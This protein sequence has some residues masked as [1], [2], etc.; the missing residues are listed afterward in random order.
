MAAA[1][2][3]STTKRD[4]TIAFQTRKYAARAVGLQCAES[5]NVFQRNSC[6]IGSCIAFAHASD[7]RSD[8]SSA[9]MQPSIFLLIRVLQN[10][11]RFQRVPRLNPELATTAVGFS[12]K[13]ISQRVAI[14]LRDFAFQETNH[15]CFVS[16]RPATST[17]GSRRNGLVL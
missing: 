4:T 5:V 11:I 8:F 2:H 13:T 16:A 7:R 10:C 9:R 3:N 1:K 12:F 6:P 15:S 14:Q 17:A